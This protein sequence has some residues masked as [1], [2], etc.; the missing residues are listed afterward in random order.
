MRRVQPNKV[1][2]QNDKKTLTLFYETGA[3][4]VYIPR[5]DDRALFKAAR[6][7]IFAIEGRFNDRRSDN[8]DNRRGSES[9]RHDRRD[10]NS[11]RPDGVALRDPAT[12]DVAGAQGTESVLPDNRPSHAPDASGGHASGEKL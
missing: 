5:A 10:D 8:E 4:Q 6:A 11:A 1:T 9:A 12:G 3:L 2:W 7:L